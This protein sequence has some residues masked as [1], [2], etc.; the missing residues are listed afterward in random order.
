MTEFIIISVEIQVE[1]SDDDILSRQNVSKNG[2][3]TLRNSA[4]SFT[5]CT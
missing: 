1:M 2:M 5:N 3:K 4:I